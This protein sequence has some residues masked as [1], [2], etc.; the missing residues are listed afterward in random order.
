MPS[1]EQKILVAVAELDPDADQLGNLRRLVSDDVDAGRLIDLVL[2]EGMGGLLYRNLQK[3]GALDRLGDECRSKLESI[4]YQTVRLNLKLLHGLKEILHQL[5]KKKIRVVLMQ[6]ISL[7][8][9]VYQDIG[10]RPMKDIDL[11]VMP[12][13]F[14]A[15]II[16]LNALG[17]QKGS[18][19]PN[20]FSKG[21]TSIDI[22]THLLW[23]DRIKARRVLLNKSQQ[24]VYDNTR[25][26][27]V[28]GHEALSLNPYDQVLYL[29]LHTIKHYAERL[30]WLMDIKC[31]IKD[32]SRSQWVEFI[33]RAAELGLKNVAAYS[34][35]LLSEVLDYQPLPETCPVLENVRPGFLE[36]MVLKKR[37]K[38]GALPTW[39]PLLLLPGGKGLRQRIAFVFEELFPRPDVLRQVFAYRPGLKVWQL[40][41]RRSLQLI[42]LIRH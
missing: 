1:I 5:N 25:S 19:Y 37:S 33:E 31:I 39:S 22:H 42:G 41:W 2:K 9:Q 3:A 35:F 10:L 30:I 17:Y 11:W 24:Y 36:K 32:W 34:V 40:Y 26:I 15:L 8:Q 13:D 18:F 29:S 20:T 12:E 4:Y 14:R 6:G 21:E 16:V 27:A 7:L 28:E 23:A 38:M